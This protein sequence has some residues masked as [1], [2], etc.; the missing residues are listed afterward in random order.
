MPSPTRFK[1]QQFPAYL[2]MYDTNL[3]EEPV[4][5]VNEVARYDVNV[6]EAAII[7]DGNFDFAVVDGELQVWAT[8]VEA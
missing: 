8:E 2:R 1:V 3:G 4:D 5:L 6:A 7:E